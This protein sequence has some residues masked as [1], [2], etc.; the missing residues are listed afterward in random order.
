MYLANK[1]KQQSSYQAYNKKH[2]NFFNIF[3]LCCLI[4]YLEHCFQIVQIHI[5]HLPRMDSLGLIGYFVPELI[6]NRLLHFDVA[7][8]M[9]IGFIV[10]GFDYLT[11]ILQGLHV[12][13]HTL[14]V[15]FNWSI[16]EI[17]FPRAELHF[18]YNT[19]VGIAMLNSLRKMNYR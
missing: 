15:I 19:I 8:F 16:G 12:I 6:R 17:W 13:E 1:H 9:Q 5:L 4:H 18:Y 2:N 3:A 14:Q 11:L 10:F 7:I